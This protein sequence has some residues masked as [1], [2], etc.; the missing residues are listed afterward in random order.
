MG[1]DYLRN[2]T[3]A[4]L[5]TV[6]RRGEFYRMPGDVFVGVS[7]G[8]ARYPEDADSLDSLIK[9]ADHIMYEVKR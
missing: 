2:F 5:E 9:K 8:C 6:D 1:D 4:T 3:R 7:I